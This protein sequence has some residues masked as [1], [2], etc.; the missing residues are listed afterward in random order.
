MNVEIL[1]N[2]ELLGM[3]IGKDR[4]RSMAKKSLAEV[5]GVKNA[6]GVT[7][8]IFAAEERAVYTAAPELIAARELVARLTLEQW[9]MDALQLSSPKAIKAYL[10][11]AIGNL[12]REVFLCMFLDS[13]NRL[14]STWVA[15]Q[16]TVDSCSVAA[17]EIV[18]KAFEVNACGLVVAHNHPSGLAEPSRPDEVLTRHLQQVTAGVGIK[19]LD[20]FVV[21]ATSAYSFAENGLM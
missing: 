7:Q 18:K 20:H 3:V 10:A 6:K 1:S 8:D 12:E 21:T 13:Q 17:R 4:A 9:Q 15:F 2:Q 5:F 19:M 14:I 16:G 11:N